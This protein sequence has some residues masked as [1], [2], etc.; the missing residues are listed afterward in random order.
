M[1]FMWK[2]DVSLRLSRLAGTVGVKGIQSPHVWWLPSE[3]CLFLLQPLLCIRGPPFS[4]WFP[5]L[6]LG[7]CFFLFLGV[8]LFFLLRNSSL[9]IYLSDN[10]RRNQSSS[11]DIALLIDGTQP[12]QHSSLYIHLSCYLSCFDQKQ[13]IYA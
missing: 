6:C 7:P 13:I 1:V 9:S 3:T 12:Q 10:T 11:P 2:T 8:K 4:F 5:R